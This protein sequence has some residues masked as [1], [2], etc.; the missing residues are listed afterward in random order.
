MFFSGIG[1]CERG[2]EKGKEEGAI[3]RD[4]GRGGEGRGQVEEVEGKKI[5]Q[6]HVHKYLS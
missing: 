5:G 3:I 1:G 4:R 6:V 2:K